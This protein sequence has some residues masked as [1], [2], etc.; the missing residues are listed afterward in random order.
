MICIEFI[1]TLLSLQIQGLDAYE[2]ELR[3]VKGQMEQ[4]IEENK[5]SSLDD[6]SL[7]NTAQP[8]DELT[9]QLFELVS[10]YSAID[11]AFYWMGKAAER[12]TISMETFAEE[13]RRRGR[14]EFYCRTLA[15]KIH[16]TME[17][18]APAVPMSAPQSRRSTE[19]TEMAYYAATSSSQTRFAYGYDVSMG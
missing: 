10:E 16:D 8:A 17:A 14:R 3:R 13:A 6:M 7:E 11:D 4:W 15:K 9:K 5:D 1:L 18:E 2:Q 19:N 12:Q